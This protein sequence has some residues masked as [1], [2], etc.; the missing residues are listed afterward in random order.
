MIKSLIDSYLE[1]IRKYY[2][3]KIDP[4][5]EEVRPYL[6]EEDL[7]KLETI[8][9]TASGSAAAASGGLAQGAIMG[10]DTPVLITIHI[11]MIISLGEI[12]GRK[13]DKTTATAL[14]GAAAGVGIGVFGVKAILGLIP[15]GG[16][17]V[18]AAISFGYTE[19]LGWTFVK[20]FKGDKDTIRQLKLDVNG[21]GIMGDIYNVDQAGAVG[22]YA[23]ADNNKF[24]HSEQKQTLDQA[25]AEIQKLLKQLEATNPTATEGEKIAYVNDET[26]PSFKRRVVGALEAGGEAVIEEFLDNPYVNVG[27][28]IVKG[29]IKPE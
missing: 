25:A 7:S 10:A 24:F 23:R 13:L 22:K 2:S 1:K 20:Y 4:I 17:I 14:L 29:W 5:K 27:K 6:K 26:T 28:A 21:E 18:N 3:E 16:N 11:G 15:I 8:I 19:L 9:H 12:F